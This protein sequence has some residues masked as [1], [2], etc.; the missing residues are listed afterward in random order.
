LNYNNVRLNMGIGSSIH[1]LKLKMVTYALR[2]K[3]LKIVDCPSTG[4]LRDVNFKDSMWVNPN[5]GFSGFV[6]LGREY[7]KSNSKGVMPEGAIHDRR[8]LF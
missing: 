2:M 6:Q 3:P 8:E 7:R 4:T 5:F 1:A